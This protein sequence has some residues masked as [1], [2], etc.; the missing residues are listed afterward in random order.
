VEFYDVN[1]PRQ[2]SSAATLEH[3]SRHLTDE[4]RRALTLT[5]AEI[6]A[7]LPA[8]QALAQ[9]PQ[10]THLD[11]LSVPVEYHFAPGEARDGAILKV[12]LVAL[13]ALTRTAVDAAI[14]GLALPRVEA[15]LRSLPK[16]ARRNL[17]PIAAT[18]AQFLA[19]NA[20]LVADA[21]QLKAWLKER[22]GIAEGLL[23]FE[24]D[25]VPAH[26][27]V[28]LAVMQGDREMAQGTDL[29]GLR[30]QCAIAGRAELDRE[31]R[32]GY[33]ILGDWRHFAADELPVQVS[34]DLPQGAITLFPA[35]ARRQ[36]ALQVRFEYSL[37]ESQRHTRDGAV[38]LARIVLER[39]TKDLAKSIASN[40]P[41]S[42]SASPYMSGDALADTLLQLG[43]RAACFGEADPPRTRAGFDTAV[44]RGRERLYPCVEEISGL[45]AAW[46]RDA[47]EI[48]QLLDQPR[49]RL[50]STAVDESRQHLRRLFEPAVLQLSPIDWL[51]QLPRYLKA[52][53]R[54]W[55]RNSARGGE[56]AQVHKE[57]EQW[58]LRHEQLKAQLDA[59]LRWIPQLDELRFWIEEYRVSL[60]AQELKTLGPISAA[61]LQQRAADIESW[62]NR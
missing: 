7:R 44:D 61:R 10:Q 1:L 8:E 53:L 19:D 3:F 55:Q 6:F 59:E 62:L 31:A 37:A 50:L 2:V 48:R 46:L 12:P 41:L 33:G 20:S 32:A 56:P 34:L 58:S 29:A 26:L 28:H 25:M 16:D 4:Q 21:V 11:E 14:P 47:A 18:A 30:R 43:V 9:F 15:L 52:E 49:V 42:L 23:R 13:P 36:S 27:T 54:R 39:Q 60:Y 57:L 38:R 45:M 51:R 40:V 22:R 35:L 24:P 17:I 5:Q